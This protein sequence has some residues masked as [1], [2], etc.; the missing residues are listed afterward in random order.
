MPA[1]MLHSGSTCS[2]LN[3]LSGMMTQ[4]CIGVLQE[5]A[6]MAQQVSSMGTDGMHSC[7]MR[8]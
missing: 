3:M 7:R 4:M 8:A 5:S 2:M 6:A 1:M